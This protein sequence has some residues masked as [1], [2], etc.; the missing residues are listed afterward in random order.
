MA[1]RERNGM[2]TVVK[3]SDGRYQAAVYV[4]TPTGHRRR[5]FV[6][7]RTWDEANDKRL[8]LLDNNRKGVPSE[9][10]AMRLDEYLTYW[11]DHIAV[12]DLRPSTF[13]RY[14]ALVRDYITPHLGRKKL[15]R[16]SPSDVRGLMAT[17]A[18][19][20]GKSGRVLSPRTIQFIHAVLRSA[21]QH[22]VRDELIGRNVAKLVSPPRATPPEITPLSPEVARKFLRVA[23]THWLA[24]LWLILLTTGLRRGEV[25]GLTWSDVDLDAGTLRVRRTVQKLDGVFVFGEPKSARSRR[26]LTLPAVCLAALRRQPEINRGRAAGE[27]R[28]VDGQPADL[29]FVSTSGQPIDPRSV[30]RAFDRL[31]TKAEVPH[32]RVHDLRHT[33]A[34]LLLAEGASDREVMELLG[35]SSIGITMNTYAH[36]LDDS[37]RRMASRMD[38]LFGE[39]G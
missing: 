17:L 31:L 28:R 22:A 25:L 23:N 20:K 1:G 39:G 9:S 16:L 14:R 6:Y 2:G 3:R 36:V 24:A 38:G 30:N 18:R 34:T 19:T 32:S 8:E 13:A 5:K 10:S 21:L 7:G 12:H 4:L 11:L 15:N 33:C 35:H 27:Q 37:K 26:V 29:V